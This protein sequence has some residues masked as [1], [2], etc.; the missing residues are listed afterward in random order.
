VLKTSFAQ[1]KAH[2]SELVDKA[3]YKKQR[4]VILR[5]G[6]P[7]A[8]LVPVDVALGPSRAAPRSEKEIKAF[9]ASSARCGDPTFDAVGD[10]LS[11]RR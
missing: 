6:K 1:A 8:A 4:I 11:G 10:L 2:L 9:F 3:Q 5:H 7:A